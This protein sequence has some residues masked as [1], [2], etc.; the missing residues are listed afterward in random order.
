MLALSIQLAEK[1][2]N[3]KADVEQAILGL[4]SGKLESSGY[5]GDRL[6]GALEILQ[7][8]VFEEIAIILY[9]A[10]IEVPAYP[11]AI[12]PYPP[13]E[14]IIRIYDDYYEDGFKRIVGG[15]PFRFV[16]LAENGFDPLKS[17]R[18]EGYHDGLNES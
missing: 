10:H 15:Q 2:P 1:N 17:Q 13:R 3:F 16:Q 9:V 8:Y 12:F 4:L 7:H 14:V 11:V 18:D 6:K 5:T